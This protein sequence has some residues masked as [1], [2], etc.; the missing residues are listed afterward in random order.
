M[1]TENGVSNIPKK[2]WVFFSV[3]LKPVLK[4]LYQNG[5]QGCIILTVHRI[6]FSQ[7]IKMH[8]VISY[9]LIWHCTAP[10]PCSGSSPDSINSAPMLSCCWAMGAPLGPCWAT[11]QG[12]FTVQQVGRGCE[13]GAGPHCQKSLLSPAKL[14]TSLLDPLQ[15][16]LINFGT[17]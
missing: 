1:S 9:N 8:T 10:S 15:D 12:R 14:S 4:F 13:A 17:E 6:V 11:W 2:C 5:K 16:C 3:I 7:W